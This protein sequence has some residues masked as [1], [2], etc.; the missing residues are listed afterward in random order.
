MQ[1]ILIK[2]SFHVVGFSPDGDSMMFR[3]ENSAHWD[4]IGGDK[5]VFAE[6][7][8][9]KE[10]AVQLR[11]QGIDALET[12]YSPRS[13][14]TP[15]ELKG[16]GSDK[17]N[18]PSPG[19]YHQPAEIGQMATDKFMQILGVK[20]TKWRTFGRNT[21]IDKAR[22]ER[23]GETVWVDD[24]LQD[25]IPGYI[26]TTE[27]E[28]NGRPLAWVFPGHPEDID[29]SVLT[30]EQL[31]ARLKQSVNYQLV[32]SGLVYP[33]FYMSMAGCVRKVM[34]TGTKL[35]QASARRKQA[36]LKKKPWKAPAKVPNLWF[37]DQTQEGVEI[38]SL[39]QLV[40][41]M[42]VY[43]YLF[44]KLAK[45]WYRQ[46]MEKYWDAVRED[47]PFAFDPE[48]L[49]LEVEGLLD[50]GNPYVF[51]IS[52]Q[53]FVRLDEILELKGKTL[54]LKRSPRDFVFLS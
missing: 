26:I 12:H 15:A 7:L 27:T 52:D 30:K 51:V 29:G 35:A 54:K 9:E 31:A 38:D 43:P 37:Y 48:D 50:D 28:R 36:Y 33:Y 19:G 46:Q 1:Y 39:Q 41:S 3:A 22:F 5:A 13:L 24:K 16:K 32:K 47:K 49:R 44:R 4:K 23:D 2:G 20:E 17:Q 40:E 42:E 45:T 21:W 10:G 25:Y 11:L 34:I 18:K 6:K 8:A 53:D 14:R